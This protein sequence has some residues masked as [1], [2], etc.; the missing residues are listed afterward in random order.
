M[1]VF[2]VRRNKRRLAAKRH[3]T[4][5]T[6][7]MDQATRAMLAVFISNLLLSFPHSIYHIV[8]YDHRVFSYV[9]MHSI[10]FT[11]LFVDPL[12][13]LCSNLHHRQRVMHALKSLLGQSSDTELASPSTSQVTQTSSTQKCVEEGQGKASLGEESC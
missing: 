2:Q 12:A 6:Q 7:V 9:I 11:H 13:F 1:L 5:V 10:F 8:P 3:T 4:G